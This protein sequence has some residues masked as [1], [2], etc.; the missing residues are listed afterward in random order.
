MIR[1]KTKARPR[2]RPDV[3]AR[4][5]HITY[6]RDAATREEVGAL[7]ERLAH[8]VR[9]GIIVGEG[10]ALPLPEDLS[11]K[12]VVGPIGHDAILRVEIGRPAIKS[13]PHTQVEAELAHPGG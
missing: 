11:V 1:M 12:V 2:V 4:S 9:A 8:H 6:E 5:A 10:E 3:R 7:L 13:Y